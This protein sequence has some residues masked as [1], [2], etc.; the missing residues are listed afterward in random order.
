[1]KEFRIVKVIFAKNAAEAVKKEHNGEIISV[2]L[3]DQ[4]QRPDESD[5]RKIGFKN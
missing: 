5:G 2:V 3:Q 1:M 4:I